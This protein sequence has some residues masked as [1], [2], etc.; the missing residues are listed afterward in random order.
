MRMLNVFFGVLCGDQNFCTLSV[1]ESFV[2]IKTADCLLEF[3]VE[4]RISESLCGAL[5]S[6]ILNVFWSFYGSQNS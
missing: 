5:G 3:L 6:E 4:I 1:V 2:G